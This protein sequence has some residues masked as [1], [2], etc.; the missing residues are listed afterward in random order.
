MDDYLIPIFAALITGD[1]RAMSA[2]M[3][4]RNSSGEVG[5]GSINWALSLARMSGAVITSDTSR[6]ILARMGSGVFAGAIRPIQASASTSI[7]DSLS[8]GMPGTSAE[9]SA[10][11]T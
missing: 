6:A 7:P 2:S 9:R 11:E 8:V 10:V 1:Q 4:A 3:R 5:I